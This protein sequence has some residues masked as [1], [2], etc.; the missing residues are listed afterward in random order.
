[1]ATILITGGSSE[2][3]TKTITATERH[4][5]PSG[6]T[7]GTSWISSMTPAAADISVSTDT[8]QWIPLSASGLI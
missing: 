1:M 3:F 2:T 4:M 7:D 6:M 5:R 8:V